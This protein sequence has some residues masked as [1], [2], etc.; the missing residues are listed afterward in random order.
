[1]TP[2]T[3]AGIFAL[4]FLASFGAS[5]LLVSV[6]RAS[7]SRFDLAPNSLARLRG[8]SGVYRCRFVRSDAQGWWFTCPI[9]RDSFVPVRVG[10]HLFV[11]A[12][13]EGRGAMVFESTIMLRDKDC[14]EICLKRPQASK[15]FERRIDSRDRSLSGQACRVNGDEGEILDMSPNGIR[16]VTHLGLAKGDEVK[17]ELPAG[18]GFAWGWVLEATPEAFGTRQG[19]CVRVRFAE[20]LVG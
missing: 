16:L 2:Q 4:I 14:H 13:V 19:T 18:N 15:V 10:E 12:P 6:K 20:S 7:R 11:E 8:T 5:Y 17:V 1:M 9:S 3:L